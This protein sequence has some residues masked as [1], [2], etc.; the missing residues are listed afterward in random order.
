ME[1]YA[2]FASVDEAQEGTGKTGDKGEG[3]GFKSGFE[4]ACR[5]ASPFSQ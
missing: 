5:R 2:S 1:E 4:K 3:L